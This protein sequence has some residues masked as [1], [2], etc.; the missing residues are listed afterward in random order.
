MTYDDIVKAATGFEEPYEYQ[1]R[2]ATAG[3][4]NVLAVPT[5]TGKT[6]AA[7]LGWLYRLLLHPDVEVGRTT[8]RRL[9]YVLP[10]RSLVQQT[11]A[12]AQAWMAALYTNGVLELDAVGVSAL[13]GGEGRLDETWR[14]RPERPH[15]VVGTQDLLLSRALNRGYIS[16]RRNWPIDFGLL[17]AGTLWV[18]DEIQLMGPALPT[19]RQL[20]GLR[21]ALGT[22]GPVQS[23]WMSATVDE[24]SLATVDNPEIGD[25]LSLT[26]ADRRGPLRKRLEATKRVTRL[27][28]AE[29]SAAYVGELAKAVVEHHQPRTL[30]IAVCNTVRRAQDLYLQIAKTSD[31]PVTLLHSRFRPRDRAANAAAALDPEIEEQG[32]IVVATQVLEAG[33]DVSATTLFTEAAPWSSIVQ[34]A[35]RCNRDGASSEA[36]LLWAR[37]RDPTPYDADAVK[38]A[39]QELDLLEGAE[40]TADSLAARKVPHKEVLHPTLRRRDLIELFDTAPD[41]SG[42]D[43]DIGRYIRDGDTR[44]VAL[45]WRVPGGESD[46]PTRDEL[47]AVSIGQVRSWLKREGKRVWRFDHLDGGWRVARPLDVRPGDVLLVDPSSGGYTKELGWN[48]DSRELVEPVQRPEADPLAASAESIAED[49]QTFESGRWVALAEHLD[50]VGDAVEQILA[51]GTFPGL[52]PEHVEAAILAGRYHDIGKAHPVFQDTLARSASTEE[53]AQRRAGGPWAKS[54]RERRARHSRRYF[55]HELVSALILMDAG[56]PLLQDVDEPDLV[57]YL[58]AA[59]HGVVRLSIRSLPDEGA[60]NGSHVALGVVN[61]DQMPAIDVPGGQ[62]PSGS[63]DLAPMTLGENLLGQP[64]WTGRVLALRDRAD[65]GPFRLATLE[66]VVR[67]ADW[68]ASHEEER[69]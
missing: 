26:D 14:L 12:V 47:C 63:L 7:V 38:L 52:R 13:L 8:P 39:V 32:R 4:P 18:F 24:R 44:D 37:P 62:I 23:M 65:I 59:H 1:R 55:R 27:D 6:M 33:I 17:H 67:V 2:I 54:V 3:F 60:S 36:V 49:R 42:A 28:L 35:G 48:P 31:M 56:A 57:C 43:L 51:N 30:T 69:R 68:R 29:D 66:A 15:I 11:V 46:A 41:L 34:R 16:S 45:A 19:S 40:V 58:V 61:G 25:V 10:Q 21:N 50:D 64:S 9:A 22:A 20:Q 53:E 5:G